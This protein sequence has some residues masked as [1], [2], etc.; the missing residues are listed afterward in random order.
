[1]PSTMTI[2]LPEELKSF[3]EERAKSGNFAS[4]SEFI[5]HLVRD[6]Q[7]RMEQERLEKML[8]E[9][10]DSG[11]SIRVSDS[12]WDGLRERIDRRANRRAAKNGK[13]R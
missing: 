1:M 5:R 2:S 13:R 6:E 9:G 3:I 4:A 12:Y 7:K 8:L 10:L 11:D